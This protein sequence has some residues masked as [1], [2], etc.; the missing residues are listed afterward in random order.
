MKELADGQGK[1]LV[2]EE[3]VVLRLLTESAITQSNL[4]VHRVTPVASMVAPREERWDQYGVR[5]G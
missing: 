1:V 2:F 4:D 5:S 3:A